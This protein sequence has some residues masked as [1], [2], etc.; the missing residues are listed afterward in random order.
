MVYDF[1]CGNVTDTF[2]DLH[3]YAFNNVNETYSCG[4]WRGL[5]PLG[6]LGNVFKNSSATA[7]KG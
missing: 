6:C 4:V 2:L 5:Q 1:I 3:V 7:W